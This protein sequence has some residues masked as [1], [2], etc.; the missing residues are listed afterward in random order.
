MHWTTV[1]ALTEQKQFLLE[2]K[3]YFF[4]S[5][6]PVNAKDNEDHVPLHFCARF[7]H[8]EIIR[9]LLQGNLDAQ[10]HSVN[11]YGDTPLHL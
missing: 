5:C 7:G 9:F 10:A 4:P 6:L 8:H 3:I 1:D 11:I 2:L